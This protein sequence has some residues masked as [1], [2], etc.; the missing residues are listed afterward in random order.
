MTRLNKKVI[1]RQQFGNTIKNKGEVSVLPNIEISKQA[2]KRIP[3]YLH[4]LKEQKK[5]GS[6]IISAPFVASALNLNE[7]QVRKDFA[8]ISTNRGRPKTGFNIDELIENMEAL[9]GYNNTNEAILV[10]AGSLGKAL[11][12]YRGFE[13]YG[14]NII[15][16]FDSDEKSIGNIIGGKPI[17][18]LSEIGNFC[19]AN[20]VNIGVI[21]VPAQAAQEVCDILVESGIRAVWNFAPANLNVH[22]GILVQNENMAASLALLSKHLREQIKKQ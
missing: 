12:S 19:K 17:L 13:D 11:L 18:A 15:A 1:I 3:V 10:G 14:L 22:E 9:V 7:V 16:A 2:I 20:K 21:T 8:A 6:T 5:N 4:Y